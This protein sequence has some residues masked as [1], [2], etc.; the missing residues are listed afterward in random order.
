MEIARL[1]ALITGD[2]KPLVAALD[3][4][5]AEIGQFAAEGAQDFSALTAGLSNTAKAALAAGTDIRSLTAALDVLQ[6]EQAGIIRG[7]TAWQIYEKEIRNVNKQ[8]DV[9]EAQL[10]VVAAETK[11]MGATASV[12]IS[13]IGKGL[14][15]ALGQLRT[16]AYIL[17][18]IGI[19]G[20]FNLA[21]EAISAAA[22]ELGIFNDKA[23]ELIDANNKAVESLT[24]E[25]NKVA[26]LVSQLKDENLTRQE[27]VERINE[28]QKLAPN[29]FSNLELEGDTVKNLTDDYANYGRAITLV[30]KIKAATDLNQ[31]TVTAQIQEQLRT[32]RDLLELEKDKSKF[33]DNHLAFVTRQ[34]YLLE[35]QLETQTKLAQE[36]KPLIAIITEAQRELDALGGN[37]FTPDDEPEKSKKK[38]KEFQ[39]AAKDT[40]EVIRLNQLALIDNNEKIFAIPDVK[41][42]IQIKTTGTDQITQIKKF[43]EQLAL[44]KEL[45]D[46]LAK[47][48]SNMF[49]E[50]LTT[51]KLSFKAIENAIASLIAQTVEAIIEMAL[52]AGILSA[53][54][55]GSFGAIFKGL[56]GIPKLAG[57][58]VVSSPTLAMV[59]ESGPEA[60]IPLSQMQNMSS[61]MSNSMTINGVLKAN[62]NDLV[63]VLNRSNVRI[64]RNNGNNFN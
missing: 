4:A 13:G 7:S 57:G 61:G 28:L 34:G 14:T 2:I 64:N 1:E 36:S 49:K 29:Y 16:L 46:S 48:F 38:L 30:A 41:P 58:G 54:T 17:P 47:A 26:I 40:F 24:E 45:A 62:G 6:A 60:V 11:A 5:Q 32:S 21:F 12:S 50:F 52:L 39:K 37:P 18:G 20:I 53:L 27:K 43:N 8:L 19:A 23:N 22:D 35:R 59:G 51:G 44:S 42:T 33:D 10:P 56:S 9:L 15:G 3:Q 31:K 55:G 25:A 63:L